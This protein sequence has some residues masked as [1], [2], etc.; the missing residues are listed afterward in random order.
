MATVLKNTFE[1]IVSEKGLVNGKNQYVPRGK[2]AV[3]YPTLEDLDITAIVKETTEEGFPIY[4]EEKHNFLFDA[5]LAAVRASARNKLTIVNGV[6]QCKEGLNIA[7][8]LESLMEA[9]TAGGN[10]KAL[11][12][13]R[14]FVNA[15]RAYM[16]TTGKSSGVQAAVVAFADKPATISLVEDASKREKIA[17]YVGDFVATIS[18]E[19]AARWNRRITQIADACSN[20]SV[21]DAEDF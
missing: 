15:F 21:L 1:M 9:G 4:Q 12:D 19:D 7:D 8:T 6:V 18:E 5:L 2:V 17:A 16:A 10:G 13:I 11:Q 14:D 3:P 20:E